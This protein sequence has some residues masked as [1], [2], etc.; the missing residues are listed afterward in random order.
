MTPNEIISYTQFTERIV[1]LEQ[2]IKELEKDRAG[3]EKL[4]HLIEGKLSVIEKRIG[5]QVTFVAGVSA[6]FSLFVFMIS[7]AGAGL[8]N[9]FKNHF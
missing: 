1:I 6:A 4:L 2:R 9:F 5:D 8:I 7:S 3:D